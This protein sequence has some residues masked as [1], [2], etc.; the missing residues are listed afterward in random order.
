MAPSV[1]LRLA[2]VVTR[3]TPLQALRQSTT[4]ASPR[5]AAFAVVTVSGAVLAG[6]G[7]TRTIPRGPVACDPVQSTYQS[8]FPSGPRERRTGMPSGSDAR[9]ARG[10][11]GMGG[12][13]RRRAASTAAPP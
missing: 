13:E 12:G 8:D 3:A 4:V 6:S 11:G 9:R 7:A 2:T 5:L 10:C 1:T